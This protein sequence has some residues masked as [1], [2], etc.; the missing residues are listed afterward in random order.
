MLGGK[1]FRGTSLEMDKPKVLI[2]CPFYLPGFKGGGPIRSISNLILALGDVCDFYVV[3]SDRD[4]GDVTPYPR[5][6]T[7]EWVQ[8]GAAR[9]KYIEP[10]WR[11]YRTLWH[12]LR[13][14][15][16]D[17]VYL[18][19]FFNISFSLFLL[20]IRR[21]SGVNSARFVLAPRGELS[22]GALSLKAS[23][24][25]LYLAFTRVL[26][27]HNKLIW[28]ATA[29][30]ERGEIAGIAKRNGGEVIISPNIATHFATP[31]PLEKSLALRIVFLSRITKKKNLEFALRVA[32]RMS[33]PVK[34]DIYGPKEDFGYWE[35]CEALIAAAP[36]N[37]DIAYCGVVAPEDVLRV[38]SQYD[39]F[40]LPTLGENYGHVI[41]EAFLAGTPVLI[42]DNTPWRD[43]KAAGVGLD[44]S[45]MDDEAFVEYLN[46]I[47]CMNTDRR[48]ELRL[49]AL[50]MGRSISNSDVAISATKNLLLG[51][52]RES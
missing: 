34:F 51:V 29:E 32:C 7:G 49:R 41:V 30:L 11:R 12:I 10:G 46:Y 14:G 4:H 8:V 24:K 26:R 16:W 36:E 35:T 47:G 50:D 23:K 17:V 48:N 5:I 27:L 38:L 2:S 1:S 25:R 20:I 31:Q 18:N 33:L 39:V 45:L 42:S 13:N 19:G 40:F 6:A 15:G 44:G 28:H 52:D 43:L 21:I 9:V 3:T 37:V 22:P